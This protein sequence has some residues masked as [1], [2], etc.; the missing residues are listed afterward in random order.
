MEVDHRFTLEVVRPQSLVINLGSSFRIIYRGEIVRAKMPSVTS[1]PNPDSGTIACVFS[2]DANW[3]S[4]SV[5]ARH[6]ALL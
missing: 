2:K 4:H 6:R 5:D 1:N 3:L